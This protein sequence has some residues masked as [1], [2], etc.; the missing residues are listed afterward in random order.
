MHCAPASEHPL[1]VNVLMGPKH[2]RSYQESTSVLLFHRTG[3]DRAG[4]RP[5]LVR[6]EILGLFVNPLTADAKYSRHN[7]WN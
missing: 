2:C 4:K 7:K 6:S 1:A 3:T 5:S